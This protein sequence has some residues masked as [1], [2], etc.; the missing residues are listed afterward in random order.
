MT[1]RLASPL[2]R[3]W[4]GLV[5]A[6]WMVFDAEASLRAAGVA[7]YAFLSLFPAL[8]AGIAFFSLVFE[9]A[10]IL[11]A[12]G[13]LAPALP[14]ELQSMVTDRLVALL[15]G[16]KA[17]GFSLALSV[18]IALWSG[19]RGVNSLLHALTLT[20]GMTPRRSVLMSF[21]WTM[22]FTLGAFVLVAVLLAG[23][24][25]LPL[26][27]RLLP[28]GAELRAVLDW[29][30]WPALIGLNLAAHL[31]L[32]RFGPERRANRAIVIWPGAITATALW[33][34]GSVLLTLYF[35]TFAVYD[36]LFGPL[37]GVAIV[38]FWFYAM[39]LFTLFGAKMNAR[40]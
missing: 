4:R 29:F 21:A 1:S 13:A 19:S 22:L 17:A 16:P 39:T 6:F 10:D 36:A 37:A 35:Q 38:M 28:H 12:V 15:Y 11:R 18:V 8:A 14:P 33:T 2:A 7:F 31:A 24:A 23:L 9:P 5:H 26:A 27:V 32:F 3:L 34:A 25:V 30:S 40:M 20:G